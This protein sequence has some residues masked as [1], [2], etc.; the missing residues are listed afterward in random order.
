MCHGKI[1]NP[2]DFQ[3]KTYLGTSTK[4]LERIVM[5]VGLGGKNH[6][7]N[8][9]FLTTSLTSNSNLTTLVLSLAI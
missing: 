8:R 4:Q 9:F 2:V 6:V 7:R 5:K 1:S 3:E